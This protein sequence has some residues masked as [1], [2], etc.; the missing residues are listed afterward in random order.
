MGS[1]LILLPVNLIESFLPGLSVSDLLKRERFESGRDSGTC[2]SKGGSF[3]IHNE[4]A[5]IENVQ[6]KGVK[7]PVE[8][9]VAKSVTDFSS[10]VLTHILK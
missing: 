3:L 8:Q 2:Q 4:E 1:V 9:F 5:G 7:V 6:A 10:G